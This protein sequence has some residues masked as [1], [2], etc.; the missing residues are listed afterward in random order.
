MTLVGVR[1]ASFDGDDGK[2][3]SGW[4]L[5]LLFSEDE[6]NGKTVGVETQRVFLTDARLHDCDFDPVANVGQSVQLTYNRYGKVSSLM[7]V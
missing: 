4:N 6:S 7:A 5:Y 3:V 2:K 1:Q